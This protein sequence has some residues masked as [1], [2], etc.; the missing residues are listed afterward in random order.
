MSS[1]NIHMQLC[2]KLSDTFII[3]YRG[4]WF[5]T[6]R[7]YLYDSYVI[8]NNDSA[9]LMNADIAFAGAIL[10]VH[11]GQFYIQSLLLAPHP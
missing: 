2:C 3:N 6:L 11:R 4:S 9:G 8:P 7:Y 1:L 10:L 5:M